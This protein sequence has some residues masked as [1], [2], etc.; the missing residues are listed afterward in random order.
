MSV[1]AVVVLEAS[2]ASS[3]PERVE[4]LRKVARPYTGITHLRLATFCRSPIGILEPGERADVGI[5]RPGCI[6]VPFHLAVN[7]K[8]INRT[9]E[10]PISDG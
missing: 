5:V 9:I 2:L 6:P 3:S 1:L 8:T 4:V 10:S 7:N